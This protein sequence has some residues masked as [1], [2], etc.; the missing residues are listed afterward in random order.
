[1]VALDYVVYR[2]SPSTATLET[3]NLPTRE[4]ALAQAR[5][6]ENTYHGDFSF[7][8]VRDTQTDEHLVTAPQFYGQ[9][10]LPAH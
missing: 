2:G 8:C 5:E 3:E 7:I 1:M 9:K 4:D 10:P 6:Y